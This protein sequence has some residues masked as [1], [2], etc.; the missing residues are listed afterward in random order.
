MTDHADLVGRV[1]LAEWLDSHQVAGWHSTDPATD[2]LTCRSAGLLVHAGTHA[3]T[4]AGHWTEEDQRQ[5]SGEMTIPTSALV[6]LRAL[7]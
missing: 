7:E 2:A 4:I 6:S 5:R 3:V 1:V